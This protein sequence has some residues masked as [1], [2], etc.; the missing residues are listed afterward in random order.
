VDGSREAVGNGL[1][2]TAEGV[3]LGVYERVQSWE[4]DCCRDEVVVVLKS[5]GGCFR[6]DSHGELF[7]RKV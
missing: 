5:K 7:R 1:E 4:R 2:G 6:A 3:H